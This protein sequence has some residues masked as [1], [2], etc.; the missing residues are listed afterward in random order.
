MD[1][2]REIREHPFFR[3]IDWDRLERLEIQPPF[4]PRTV[5]LNRWTADSLDLFSLCPSFSSFPLLPLCLT[6]PLLLSSSLPDSPKG[7]F[8]ELKLSLCSIFYPALRLPRSPSFPCM[9]LVSA[10]QNVFPLLPSF[11]RASFPLLRSLSVTCTNF[12]RRASGTE[13]R[14]VQPLQ[15]GPL[16]SGCCLLLPYANACHH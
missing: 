1:A 3:W 6:S 5:S 14:T 7:T 11:L 16:T 4:K 10:V 9:H 15:T 8:R 12:H 13:E 2:E